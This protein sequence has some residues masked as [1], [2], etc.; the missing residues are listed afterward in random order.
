MSNIYYLNTR[1]ERVDFIEDLPLLNFDDFYSN[2]FTV[3]SD[4][5]IITDFKTGIRNYTLNGDIPVLIMDDITD[6]FDY[7]V[8]NKSQGRFY[9][10]DYYLLCNIIMMKPSNVNLHRKKLRISLTVTTDKP[11]W[12][13][14][15]KY[16]FIKGDVSQIGLKYPFTYPFVYGGGSGMSE[17]VNDYIKPCDFKLIVYGSVSNPSVMIGNN[18]YT[19]YTDINSQERIEIDSRNR[20]AV[21]VNSVGERLS[22]FGL[23]D[24]RYEIYRKIDIGLNQ[25]TWSGSFGFD[26]FLYEERSRP[27]WISFTQTSN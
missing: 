14:E 15:T 4:N 20:T 10:G 1:N 17:V 12:L 6:I 9:I 22:I 5:N 7:D 3:E 25:V 8:Y 18:A 13:K 11:F 21:K 19:I 26:L 16:S 27:K 24:F 2:N 23:Q